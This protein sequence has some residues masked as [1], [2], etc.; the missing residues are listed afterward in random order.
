[1]C[2]LNRAGPQQCMCVCV[3]CMCCVCVCVCV[4]GVVHVLCVCV[5]VFLYRYVSRLHVFFGSLC[6]TDMYLLCIPQCCVV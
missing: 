4:C 6:P 1:M 5:C 2:L 3:W